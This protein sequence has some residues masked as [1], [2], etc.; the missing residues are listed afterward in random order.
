MK[1]PGDVG[2]GR[3]GG[4]LDARDGVAHADLDAGY[5]EL[6]K[7]LGVG[8]AGDRVLLEDVVV[9]QV[10]E[11]ERKARIPLRDGVL[12]DLSP[13]VFPGEVGVVIT[14]AVFD[15]RRPGYSFRRVHPTGIAFTSR[16]CVVRWPS[17]H[18]A[19]QPTHWRE[20]PARH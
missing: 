7:G 5:S 18:V 2:P 20:D 6:I 16:L 17:S 12:D 13:V 19:P 11:I 15:V 1:Q 3:F 10:L 8:L 14:D 9:K 4:A